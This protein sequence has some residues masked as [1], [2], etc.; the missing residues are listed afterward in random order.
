MFARLPVML[1]DSKCD[2]LTLP[3]KV[4]AEDVRK[5]LPQRGFYSLGTRIRGHTVE[6]KIIADPETR[7]HD[8]ISENL[9]MLL[10]DRPFLELI[11]VSSNLPAILFLQDKLLESV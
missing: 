5:N 2:S 6:T 7:F 4:C 3:A 11:F 8:L 10:R 1:Y 9:L